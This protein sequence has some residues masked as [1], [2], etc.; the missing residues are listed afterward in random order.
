MEGL[1]TPSKGRPLTK[2]NEDVYEANASQ[3]HIR[4]P[5]SESP[6][7]IPLAKASS[8]KRLTRKMPLSRLR[9][10]ASSVTI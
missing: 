5:R 9:S 8:F 10:L 4:D 1:Q 3:T 6:G 7:A 2:L